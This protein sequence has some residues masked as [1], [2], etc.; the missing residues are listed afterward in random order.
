MPKIYRSMHELEGH[1]RVGDGSSELGVRLPGGS[2]KPDVYPDEG[3]NLAPGVGGM[4]VAPAIRSLLLELPTYV[5]KRLRELAKNS[6]LP[7]DLRAL[8]GRAAG[9]NSLRVWSMGQGGFEDGAITDLLSLRADTPNHGFV[10][11]TSVMAVATYQVA[12]QATVEEWVSA[13]SEL[14]RR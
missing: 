6:D 2:G 9:S 7:A 11:P 12:L 13:E 3:G 14:I 8:L 4:S 10:E 1:P 5:P